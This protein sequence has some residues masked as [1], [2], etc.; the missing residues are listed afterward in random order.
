M[1]KARKNEQTLM[2]GSSSDRNTALHHLLLAILK[3][4]QV[5]DIFI[6]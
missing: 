5:S 6:F 2:D 1:Q 3:Y 4:H